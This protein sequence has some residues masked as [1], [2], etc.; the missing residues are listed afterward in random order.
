VSGPRFQAAP[1]GTVGKYDLI[2]SSR[3][4]LPWNI[5]AV[6]VVFSKPITSADVNSLTGNL[7]VGNFSGLGTST[8]TWTFSSAVS[9]GTFATALQGSGTHAITD[10]FGNALTAGSGFMQNFKVLY[11]DFKDSGFVDSSNML[12][13]Y[14]ATAQPYNIFADINGDGMVN[15][16]DV[17]ATRSRIGTHL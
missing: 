9:I 3:N 4:D 11:G 5:T 17:I 6:Q 10:A 2:G 14:Y 16:S 1:G 7:P 13:V 8:L 12:S 15:L